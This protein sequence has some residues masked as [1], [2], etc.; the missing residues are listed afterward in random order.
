MEEAPKYMGSTSRKYR[1]AYGVPEAG[2]LM[3][4][5]ADSDIHKVWY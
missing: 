2:S 3:S 1:Y 4:S 5:D